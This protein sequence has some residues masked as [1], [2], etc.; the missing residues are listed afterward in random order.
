M[1]ISDDRQQLLLCYM[2]ASKDCLGDLFFFFLR[3][4]RPPIS[5]LFPYT[6]L[7]RSEDADARGSRERERGRERE[8]LVAAALAVPGHVDDGLPARDQ[9][10]RGLLLH[11]DHAAGEGLADLARSE[12]HTSELQSPCNLV[13]RLLLG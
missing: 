10:A 1:L 3:I 5:P 9:R 8:L 2:F 13:C 12:E 4:R 11:L 7:F 6:P